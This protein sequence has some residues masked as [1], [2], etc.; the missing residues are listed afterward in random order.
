[1]EEPG[2]LAEDVLAFATGL[3]AAGEQ[4]RTEL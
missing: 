3:V 1:M 4:E 2:L